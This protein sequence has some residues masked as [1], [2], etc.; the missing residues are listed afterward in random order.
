[1]TEYFISSSHNT[2]LLANQLY[3]AA[4]AQAYTTGTFGSAF[5]I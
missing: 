3:G 1:M 2:Y 5:V 4:S